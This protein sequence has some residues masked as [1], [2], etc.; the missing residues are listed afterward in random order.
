MR[1]ILTLIIAFFK[2]KISINDESAISFYCTIGDG[3]IKHM[4]AHKFNNFFN[5]SLY[6]LFIRSGKWL[7]FFKNKMA[8]VY[9]KESYHYI[10]MIKYGEFQ[11]ITQIIHFDE[12]YFYVKIRF[13]QDG[14]LCAKAYYKMCLVKNNKIYPF[15]NIKDK[16]FL[17]LR[18]NLLDEDKSFVIS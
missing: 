4:R 11:T 7:D 1:L 6:T 14:K 9:T 5:P 15:S 3:A 13:F 10:K 17:E 18:S 8:I 16:V 2:S 12:K